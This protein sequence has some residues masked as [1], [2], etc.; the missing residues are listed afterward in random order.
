M[1]QTW[2]GCV[3]WSVSFMLQYLYHILSHGFDLIYFIYLYC[4]R[5][6]VNHKSHANND[7]HAWFSLFAHWHNCYCH[8]THC[9]SLM[10]VL[11]HCMNNKSYKLI[12]V[13]I[14]DFHIDLRRLQWEVSANPV[15]RPESGVSGLQYIWKSASACCSEK[16]DLMIVWEFIDY[17]EWWDV[18]DFSVIHQLY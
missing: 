13:N 2:A 8:L 12:W 11:A 14:C 10:E 17:I 15:V 16:R 7:I 3:H 6:T 18:R 4:L 5:D 1:N 9:K